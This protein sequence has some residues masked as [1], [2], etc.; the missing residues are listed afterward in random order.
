MLRLSLPSLRVTKLKYDLSNLAILALLAT[1]KM[2]GNGSKQA[3]WTAS[4]RRQ[5]AACSPIKR[6]FKA[7]GTPASRFSNSSSFLRTAARTASSSGPS[8]SDQVPMDSLPNCDHLSEVVFSIR[9]K[10]NSSFFWVSLSI[11]SLRKSLLVVGQTVAPKKPF[12][13][14]ISN[15]KTT[16]QRLSN[17]GREPIG[18]K[19][20]QTSGTKNKLLRRPIHD[21]PATAMFSHY[22]FN[23]ANQSG[24]R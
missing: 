12:V 14:R 2:Q 15:L 24:G 6:G 17:L 18:G 20:S 23:F 3:S 11:T 22:S 5:P 16:Q 19:A 4:E 21:V 1:A 13:S 8:S 9:R 10:P 7:F